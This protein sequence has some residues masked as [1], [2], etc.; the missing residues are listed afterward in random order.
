MGVAAKLV[1][2]ESADPDD[3][4]PTAFGKILRKTSLDELP[5][6]RHIICLKKRWWILVCWM[7]RYWRLGNR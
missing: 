7:S 1:S 5:V 6:H 4:K 3:I 2:P